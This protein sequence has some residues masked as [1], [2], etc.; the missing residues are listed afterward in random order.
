MY[1]WNRNMN[2]K[3][4]LYIEMCGCYEVTSGLR[5]FRSISKKLPPYGS[6]SE[7]NYNYS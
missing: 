6:L 1:V 4:I 7:I 2:Q 3:S 5:T